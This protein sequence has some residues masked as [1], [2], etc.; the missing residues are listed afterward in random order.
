MKKGVF[1]LIWFIY[2]HLALGQSLKE[3][4]RQGMKYY[5]EGNYTKAIEVF[6]KAVPEAEKQFGKNHKNYTAFS[7][8]LAMM[9]QSQGLYSKAEPVY[10]E[11]MEIDAK[12]LGKEH[13]DYAIDCNNLALLYY[14]QG[15]YVKAEPL[16]LEAKEI[17]VKVFGKKHP[18]Y[19][20]DC[21]NL[22]M[23]YLA[24][25]LYTKAE[26]LHLEAKE[27]RSTVL[28]KKHPDYAL[29]CNNLAGMYY[30]QK[31][32]SKAE[33]LYLEAKE[34]RAAI[35][36]TQ[37]P[38][39]AQSC[40][41]LAALYDYQ[42]LYSKAEPLYLEAKGIYEKI[43]GKQHPL[44]AHACNNLAGLYNHQ[45]LYT[46]AEP[47]YL[48]A[49]DIHEKVLGTQH[50]DYALSC[51][52]LAMLYWSLQNY[53]KA[54]ALFFEVSQ[55]LTSQ[56]QTNFAHLSEKEKEQFLGK[57]KNYFELSYSF[58]LDRKKANL[59]VWLYNNTLTTKAILFASSQNIR[60]VV[61][62]S[63]QPELQKLL[64][65]WLAQRERL[66]KMMTMSQQEKLKQQINQ[67]A[68]EEKANHL[69]K[70][71]SVQSEA[72]SGIFKQQT[73]QWK[74]IQK[75]LKANE[76]AIEINRVRCYDSKKNV[77]TDSILYVALI[78]T[79][80]TQNMPE[81]VVLHHGKELET[82]AIAYYQNC[83]RAKKNDKES[84][85]LFWKPL[86]A[87]IGKAQKIYVAA[88]GIYHQINLETLWE[89]QTEKYVKDKIRIH[90][91]GSTRDIIA[92][93]SRKQ[94]QYKNYHLHLFGY[95][96]YSG[97]NQKNTSEK[98]RTI[99]SVAAAK[100][101]K[102]QRFLDGSGFVS[103]L[104][105]TK[106]EVTNIS[107]KA[108]SKGIQVKTY[109][110]TQANEETLKNVQGAHILH[111]ATHGFFEADI[112]RE[113]G[114][115]KYENPLLRSG[116]LLA[117]AELALQGKASGTEDGI[118]TAQEVMNLDLYGTD[119]VVLSACETGL[120]EIRNGEGVYG[121]HRAFQEAGAKSVVMS[122]WKVDDGATQ[123]MMSLFYENM[124]SKNLGKREA[125]TLAQAELQKKYPQPYYWGAFVLIG[126]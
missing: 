68:E 14:A 114:G 120:G 86:E 31:I 73:Y 123:E 80:Q 107:V 72:I 28:G 46:K 22:G 82:T 49:K 99:T 115:N 30:E 60:K 47:L 64:A 54:E 2:T 37:H 58:A 29:S 65:K 44:Y 109:L 1:L 103:I 76:A 88:D 108:K 59:S 100:M 112:D 94:T 104:E 34:I 126:E 43:L 25:G 24:Q 84:Y 117:N 10:L 21:N 116:L 16:Y 42:G 6:E 9:Y 57:L 69:E 105:G 91:V 77:F 32:Y 8:N 4:Y 81:I 45:M 35:L 74:D 56:L 62:K 17:D 40:N 75:K 20:T 39:Y 102:K 89:P 71:L 7:G 3:L 95:P 118:L 38:D 19:A 18:N 85:H 26:A 52:N 93:V 70:Q 36:G 33:P 78:V 11:V 83:I 122:L 124:L 41:N 125:F 50:L 51:N 13:P 12:V 67:K 121:L 119:L 61:K 23:L 15:L 87:K 96:D 66:A 110:E 98:E 111:I 53:E 113:K 48:E 101:S 90:L 106:T 97:S 92:L 63:N 55:T 27:I 79:P 5:G